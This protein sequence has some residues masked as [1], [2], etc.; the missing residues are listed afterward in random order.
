MKTRRDDRL[1]NLDQASRAKLDAW[2]KSHTYREVVQLAAAPP[3]VG[4]GLQTNIRALS[5]YYRKYLVPSP[6]DRLFKLAL[7]NPAAA[8]SAAV[9]MLQ[10]Q[11]CHVA[12]SPDFNI[13]TFNAVT[14]FLFRKRN[15]DLDQ[16]AA[17]LRQSKLANHGSSEVSKEHAAS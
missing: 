7:T 13:H 6:V 5:V 10:A 9:A 11:A 8:Q 16:R 3:P 14:R 17:A 12:S 15:A 2:L 4:L 1:S